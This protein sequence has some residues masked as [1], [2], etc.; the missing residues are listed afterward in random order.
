[1][2]PFE[3]A[4]QVVVP[5]DPTTTL[6]DRSDLQTMVEH[7]EPMPVEEEFI[8]N[9][10]RIQY[11][12]TIQSLTRRRRQIRFDEDSNKI[13][14]IPSRKDLTCDEKKAAYYTKKNYQ[15]MR[16]Q[17]EKLAENAQF[18]RP[19]RSG[20]FTSTYGN[21]ENSS[22]DG[23]DYRGLEALTKSGKIHHD[24]NVQYAKYTVMIAQK[25]QRRRKSSSHD[26]SSKE[27]EAQSLAA[28]YGEVSKK[29]LKEAQNRGEMYAQI[30]PPK[31]KPT[32]T[33]PKELIEQRRKRAD[34]RRSFSGRHLLSG[35]DGLEER[36]ARILERAKSCRNF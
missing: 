5:V 6:L 2:R 26:G 21:D 10:R 16:Q 32:P 9:P 30:E 19:S 34:G 17:A 13:R 31:P 8:V 28:A 33:S 20:S 4:I 36:R 29:C 12:S 27:E 14:E 25:K 23:D 1:M 11:A 7:R 22:S 3:K 18:R 15:F 35:L 24:T